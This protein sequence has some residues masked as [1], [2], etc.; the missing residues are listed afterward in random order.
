MNEALLQHPAIKF[1][2]SKSWW[3]LMRF[4]VVKPLLQHPSKL[5]LSPPTPPV[6]SPVHGPLPVLPRTPPAA[7]LPH[8][9]LPLRP[10]PWRPFVLIMG[11][12]PLPSPTRPRSK[13]A[14]STGCPDPKVAPL[15]PLTPQMTHC[16]TAHLTS[17]GVLRFVERPRVGAAATE[18]R[19]EEERAA[20]FRLYLE[21]AAARTMDEMGLCYADK[22]AN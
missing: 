9:P 2:T 16:C 1:S 3:L 20:T 19:K 4:Q 11:A 7:S 13:E 8:P 22:M 10:R 17:Y 12:S 14:R 6:H 21:V 15:R 5:S 18:S